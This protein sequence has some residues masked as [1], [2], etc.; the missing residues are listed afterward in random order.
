MVNSAT[1]IIDSLD[2][3]GAESVCSLFLTASITGSDDRLL[4][5]DD[6]GRHPLIMLLA[7]GNI[8]TILFF[9]PPVVT[10]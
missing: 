2:V 10:K 7:I 3:L 9:P 4:C 6:C 1:T 5:E 8:G